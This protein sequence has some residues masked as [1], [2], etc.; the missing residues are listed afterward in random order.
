[1]SA[2]FAK[3]CA[4]FKEVKQSLYQKGLEFQILYSTWVKFDEESYAFDSREAA[5]TF[6]NNA[7][8][9]RNVCFR[10]LPLRL[11]DTMRSDAML[12]YNI[13]WF[14]MPQE[15]SVEKTE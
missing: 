7:F 15:D 11:C 1:M 14:E 13:Y 6:S 9:R 10:L 12:Y 4:D 3:K 8:L 5:T 2:A